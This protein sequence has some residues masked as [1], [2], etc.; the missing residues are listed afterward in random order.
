M[1]RKEATRFHVRHTDITVVVF[2]AWETFNCFLDDPGTEG[3]DPE[4]VRR[5]AGSIWVDHLHP[6]SK[7][8]DYIAKRIAAFLYE[9]PTRPS[10]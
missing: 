8:H 3:F 6:T 5:R 2:S 7:V 9:I 4:D 10:M 1:L